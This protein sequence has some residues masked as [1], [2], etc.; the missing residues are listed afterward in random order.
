MFPSLSL[1]LE[2][3]WRPNLQQ[4]PTEAQLAQEEALYAAQREAIRMQEPLTQPIGLE[5]K[6]PAEPAQPAEDEDDLEEA[7][8]EFTDDE[9]PAD[10]F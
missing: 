9:G 2:L 8:E 7:E 5:K 6:P 10:R 3:L 4:A 1:P